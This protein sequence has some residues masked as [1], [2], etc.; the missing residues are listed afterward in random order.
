MDKPLLVDAKYI[1]EA[2][3]YSMST[4]KTANRFHGFPSPVLKLA[5]R[6]QWRYSDIEAWIKNLPYAFDDK[7]KPFDR[8][9][10]YLTG[11]FI[12]N[13]RYSK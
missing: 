5:N 12:S 4:I 1:K 7:G 13:K 6:Y 2:L 3:G 10:N 8:N 9:M 11:S